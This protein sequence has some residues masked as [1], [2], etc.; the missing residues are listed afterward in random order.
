VEW[1]GAGRSNPSG[2]SRFRRAGQTRRSFRRQS[3]RSQ[4][5]SGLRRR[6]CAELHRACIRSNHEGGR[7]GGAAT[8]PFV[9]VPVPLTLLAA[10]PHAV[11]DVHDGDRR[12]VVPRGSTRVDHRG[13]ADRR[14]P[15]Q[16]AVPTDGRP[17]PVSSVLRRFG[18][19]CVRPF[20][21]CSARTELSGL[22]RYQRA[23][24]PAGSVIFE[25]SMRR[26]CRH[27]DH[28]GRS[29]EEDAASCAAA[30]SWPCTP[31]TER[32]PS[33]GISRPRQ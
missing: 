21:G 29:A 12:R 19:M 22:A 9:G 3:R 26:T 20:E 31:P 15:G 8:V 10:D 13:P 14:S 24:P 28:A 25:A 5:G 11:R 4:A 16:G 2:V 17:L 1:S 33:T 27:R 7:Q 32:P 23:F 30:L 18:R 6:P